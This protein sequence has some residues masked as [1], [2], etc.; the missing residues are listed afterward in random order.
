MTDDGR[1]F[2]HSSDTVNSILNDLVSSHQDRLRNGQS[3]RF[4]GLHID[5]QWL[6]KAGHQSAFD[7]IG[8][9]AEHDGDRLGRLLGHAGRWHSCRQDEVEVDLKAARSGS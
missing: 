3:Q 9:E 2:W 1:S 7:W 5:P 4:G 6:R 8:T